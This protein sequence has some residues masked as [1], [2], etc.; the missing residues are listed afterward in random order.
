M[1]HLPG[2][3]EVF[4]PGLESHPG[5]N[6][7]KLQMRAF[8]GMISFLVN[9]GEI[10]GKKSGG[11]VTIIKAATSLGGIESIWEHRKSTEGSFV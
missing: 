1:T 8:G 7:A 9:G 4:Y 10:C 6:I 5:H 11:N 3:E 2:I